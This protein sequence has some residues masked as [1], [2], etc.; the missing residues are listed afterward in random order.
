VAR[1][2]ELAGQGERALGARDYAAAGALFDQALALDPGSER[3][4]RG[5]GAVQAALAASRRSL[6]AGR[7]VVQGRGAAKGGLA[8]F[9]SDDVSVQKA[10]DFSGQ[11]QFEV[12]PSG[13]RPG[14][15]FAVRVFVLN[16]GKKSVKLTGLAVTTVVDGQRSASS[17]PMRPVEV[18]PRAKILLQEL[19]GSLPASGG[20]WSLEVTVTSSR[21]ETLRSRLDW[22]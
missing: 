22:K 15:S 12:D 9:E 21:S 8:G 4:S 6:V 17:V 1:A 2:A 3:A 16:D 13:P 18:D 19:Q 20:S 11:I 7:T 5:R 14:D 10:P